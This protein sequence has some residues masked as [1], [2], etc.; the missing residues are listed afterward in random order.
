MKLEEIALQT[1]GG[2]GDIDMEERERPSSWAP[3]VLLNLPKLDYKVKPG[4]WTFND[5]SERLIVGEGTYGRVYRCRLLD[6]FVKEEDESVD[7]TVRYK[8]L[9][10]IKFET[11]KDGFPIT[12]LR[13]IQILQTIAHPNIV[14]LEDVIISSEKDNLMAAIGSPTSRPNSTV[15]LA[16]EFVPYDLMGILNLKPKYSPVQI[17]L[18]LR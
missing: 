5:F 17:T 10:R 12:A 8:A 11:G 15:F 14:R 2:I 3:P 6:K 13:E 7:W 18:L 1:I 4:R 16:F 9:K